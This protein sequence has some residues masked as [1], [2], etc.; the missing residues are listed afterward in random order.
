MNHSLKKISYYF[1]VLTLLT[2]P[3]MVSGC[4][5]TPAPAAPQA[6]Q[7]PAEKLYVKAYVLWGHGDTCSDPERAIALLNSALDIDANYAP[8]LLRR[9]LAFAQLGHY[10]DAFNDVTRAI[11]LDPSADNYAWRAYV[12]L[13]EGNEAGA[14]ADL[15]FAFNLNDESGRAWNVLGLLRMTQGKN[16][17]ACEAFRTAAKEGDATWLLRTRKEQICR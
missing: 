15:D 10:D 13:C 6:E 5:G 8:A 3:L 4:A 7:S 14:Q 2:L 16:E 12:L 1:F 9:G 11:H 17:E